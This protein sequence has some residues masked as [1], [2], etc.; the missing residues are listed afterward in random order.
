[1]MIAHMDLV[2]LEVDDL[3]ERFIKSMKSCPAENNDHNETP[4]D[5]LN[6]PRPYPHC[7]CVHSHLFDDLL[8]LVPKS[9]I[10]IV[11]SVNQSFTS[12]SIFYQTR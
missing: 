4:K 2:R 10:V 7:H 12:K 3:L 5:H 6:N 9:C 11:I 1:M 8:S